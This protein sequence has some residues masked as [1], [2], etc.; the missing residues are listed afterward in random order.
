MDKAYFECLG[1]DLA[2]VLLAK[3]TSRAESILDLCL[4]A[5][6]LRRTT[7]GTRTD[8]ATE[9]FRSPP[10]VNG[11]LGVMKTENRVRVSKGPSVGGLGETGDNVEGG[12]G[13]GGT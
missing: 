12:E 6:A 3:V 13:E 4:F 1:E 5:V 11:T 10:P 2:N 9:Y 8:G 7:S